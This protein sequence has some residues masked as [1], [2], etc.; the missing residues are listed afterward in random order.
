MTRARMVPTLLPGAAALAAAIAIAGCATS[1]YKRAGDAGDVASALARLQP[2]PT[3]ARNLAVLVLGGTGGPRLAAYDLA[4]SRVLWTQPA[5]VTTRVVLGGDV[6]VHGSKPAAGGGSVAVVGRDLGNGAVLWQQQLAAGERLA[7]YDT[8]SKSV[9]LVVQTGATAG[10]V[11]SGAAVVALDARAGTVRWRHPLPSGRAAGPAARDGLVAVPVDSQYVI[12][13]D[14]ATGSELAQVLS[15][16][17]AASFVRALPEGMFYGSRG[18]FLLSPSTARGSTREPG[19][20]KAGM[21]PFVRPFYWYDLY[22]PEQTEYSALDRNHILWRVSVDGD[23]ARFRDDLTVV[24]DYKFFFAFDATSGQLRWARA[25]AEDAVS[26]TDTGRAI[27]FASALGD[28]VALDRRTGAKLYEAHLPGE[29]VRGAAFDAEGFGPA[30]LAGAPATDAGAA[31]APSELVDTLVTIISDK[32]R[33]FPDV[34]LFAIE[35]L[36]RQPGREP[37][38]KLLDIMGKEGLPPLASQKVGEALAARRDTQSSDMLAGALRSTA[39]YADGQTAPPV[40]FLAKAVGALGAGGRVVSPELVAQLRR[41]ETPPAAATQIARALA[42]TGADDAVPA[43]RDFLTMYRADPAYDADPTAL[44]A[45]AEALLKLGGPAD[46][47]LL[48]FVA[49]EPHTAAGLRA[50]LTRA[51]GETAPARTSARD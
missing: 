4:G 10:R 22:R 36:G 32:D 50:H 24:H 35:E 49:E 21:P 6:L 15:T 39:D 5:E 46:R 27:L 14:S 41:P 12:L 44:I 29:I 51:L 40:E 2:P 28:I 23:R 33:R 13:L 45:A 17:E 43:L 42:A 37:T 31:T 20:L 25:Y 8:D 9:Y 48:L 11:A 47:M 1:P 30:S 38:R 34:K 26:S 19:Y 3:T 7:G 18:V 16:T